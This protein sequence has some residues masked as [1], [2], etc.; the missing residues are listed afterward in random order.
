MVTSSF[1]PK[2]SLR[3]VQVSTIE[4]KEQQTFGLAFTAEFP[5]FGTMSG[6]AKVI[7][8]VPARFFDSLAVK[9]TP[10]LD[11]PRGGHPAPT[12]QRLGPVDERLDGASRQEPVDRTRGGEAERSDGK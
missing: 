1:K 6:N 2:N 5:I 10:Q 9:A 11:R 12:R 8:I 7:W 4:G 3:R